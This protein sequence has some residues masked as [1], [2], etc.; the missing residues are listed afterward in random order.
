MAIILQPCVTKINTMLDGIPDVK[1]IGA[2]IN[3]K[4]QH[5]TMDGAKIK[6]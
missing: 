3:Q 4:P 1:K 2:M 6:G 5:T